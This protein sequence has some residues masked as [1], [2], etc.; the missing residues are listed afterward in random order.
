MQKSRFPAE[1]FQYITGIKHLGLNTLKGVR[2][3]V[4]FIWVIPFLR[5]PSLV[6]ETFS[7]HELPLRK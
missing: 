2:G 6:P 4:D 1:K 5:W 3:T 7:R